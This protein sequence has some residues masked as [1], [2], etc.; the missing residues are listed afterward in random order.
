MSR[1]RIRATRLVSMLKYMAIATLIIGR[2]ANAHDD[3]RYANSPLHAWFEKLESKKGHCCSD[4]DGRVIRNVDWAS[5]DGHYRVRIDGE[6]GDG[7]E[8]AVVTEPNQ[9]GQKIV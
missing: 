7:P 3:G 8:D 2:F 4:A 6:W 5:H 9:T 1:L